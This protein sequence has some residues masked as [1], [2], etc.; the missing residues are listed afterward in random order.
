MS[1]KPVSTGDIDAVI[2][3]VLLKRNFR[4]IL[5]NLNGRIPVYVLHCGIHNG[6]QM[7]KP[8]DRRTDKQKENGA[9]PPG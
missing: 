5:H 8:D 4:P 3:N 6:K 1:R 2:I 7:K 9:K